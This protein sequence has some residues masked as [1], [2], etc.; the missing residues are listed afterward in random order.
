MLVRWALATWDGE[1]GRL[2]RGSP[3]SPP[4]RPGAAVVIMNG[5]CPG[6][7]GGDA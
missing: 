4:L 2:G 1:W 3:A 6:I 7:V 5:C